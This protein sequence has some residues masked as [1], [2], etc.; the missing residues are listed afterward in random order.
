MGPGYTNIALM[1]TYVTYVAAELYGWP[2]LKAYAAARL[3]R[4]CDYTLEQGAFTEYNSPTY[5]LDLVLY[6]GRDREFDLTKLSAAAL[7]FALRPTTVAATPPPITHTLSDGRLSLVWDTLR[8]S[9]PVRP[10]TVSTLQRAVT[11]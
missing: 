1:G 11:Y 8:V 6:A 7:G 5:W 2:D 10:A 3:R 4:F 9:I